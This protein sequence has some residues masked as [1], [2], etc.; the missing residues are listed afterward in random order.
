MIW[1][2]NGLATITGGKLTIFRIMAR[3][4]LKAVRPFLPACQIPSESDPIFLP[5][6]ETPAEN[7]GLSQATWRHLY[8]RYGEQAEDIVRNAR[9]ADLFTV[10][11][12]HTL[13]AEIPYAARNE[14]IRHLD[15]LLLRRIRIGLMTPQ[16]GKVHLGRIRKLCRPCLP[17]N[18]RKWRREIHRYLNRWQSAHG[19]PAGLRPAPPVR[20]F[21]SVSHLRSYIADYARRIFSKSRP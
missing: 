7:A 11:G 8:G 15:D 16:G 5:V 19:L 10:P 4:A 1:K 13:W 9:P 6:P 2:E 14:G 3:D 12:T 20:L 17:W 21:P 18:N